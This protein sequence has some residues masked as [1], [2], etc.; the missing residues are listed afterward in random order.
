MLGAKAIWRP[1]Q[2]QFPNF[3]EIFPQSSLAVHILRGPKSHT[4]ET[5]VVPAQCRTH[6]CV[7][8]ARNPR[9]PAVFLKADSL[10]VRVLGFLRSVCIEAPS[11]E[12]DGTSASA[13]GLLVQNRYVFSTLSPVFLGTGYRGLTVSPS[14]AHHRSWQCRVATSSSGLR[15]PKGLREMPKSRGDWYM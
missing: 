11:G 12:L 3:C 4:S 6:Q 15:C 1:N 7:C 5:S 9:D 8:T 13:F 2:R 10:H 14:E